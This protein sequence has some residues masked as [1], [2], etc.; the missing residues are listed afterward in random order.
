[1][2]ASILFPLL[3]FASSQT[4]ACVIKFWRSSNFLKFSPNFYFLGHQIRNTSYSVIFMYLSALFSTFLVVSWTGVI[5]DDISSSSCSP[6]SPRSP[7]APFGLLLR[8][9]LYPWCRIAPQTIISNSPFLISSVLAGADTRCSLIAT[10][11]QRITR[12]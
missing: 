8:K 5:A 7:R 4:T 3:F 6:R 9:F 12:N 2:D 10:I 11:S 1:M